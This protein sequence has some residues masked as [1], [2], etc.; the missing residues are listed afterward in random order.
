MVL[1]IIN[2]N[3]SSGG[4]CPVSTN[5]STDIPLVIPSTSPRSNP[6]ESNNSHTTVSSDSL[7][8]VRLI[9]T[10]TP[11]AESTPISDLTNTMTPPAPNFKIRRATFPMTTHNKKLRTSNLPVKHKM[12]S[13]VIYVKKSTRTWTLLIVIWRPTQEPSLSFV[14]YAPHWLTRRGSL[15]RHIREDHPSANPPSSLLLQ[16]KSVTNGTDLALSPCQRKRTT[17]NRP[18]T[19]KKQSCYGPTRPGLPDEMLSNSD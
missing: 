4:L 1:F 15:A 3:L 2:P 13:V 9:P 16:D 12:A 8:I 19:P 14:S 6:P 17:I 10:P 5:L 18:L 11:V 7:P